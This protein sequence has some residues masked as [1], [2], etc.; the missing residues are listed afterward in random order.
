MIKRVIV[1]MVFAITALLA[2]SP[3]CPALPPVQTLNFDFGSGPAHVGDD[4]VLSSPGGTFWN[5]VTA[6]DLNNPPSGLLSELD[7]FDEFGAVTAG[8]IGSRG[9]NLNSS[10]RIIGWINNLASAMG[11]IISDGIRPQSPRQSR[12]GG[13]TALF[14]HVRVYEFVEMVIYFDF[15]LPPTI[16]FADIASGGFADSFAP[17]LFGFDNLIAQPLADFT[18]QSHTFGSTNDP[19]STLSYIHITETPP[20]RDALG[21][22]NTLTIAL[23]DESPNTSLG[24]AA[25]QIRGVFGL[26]EPTSVGIACVAIICVACGRIRTPSP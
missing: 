26:P 7:T 25:I 23:P 14:S 10:P 15:E 1:T 12:R 16:P 22:G 13:G 17:D 5:R 9:P 21:A 11:G 2:I 4:G 19:T 24:I 18:V 8:G 6:S 3:N 20:L